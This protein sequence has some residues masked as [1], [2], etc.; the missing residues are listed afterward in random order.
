MKASPRI[1]VSRLLF[2]IKHAERLEAA[3]AAELDALSDGAFEFEL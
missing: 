3:T 2:Q 1:L